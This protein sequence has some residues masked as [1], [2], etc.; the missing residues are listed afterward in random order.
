[1]EQWPTFFIV[2]AQ[3]A[4]TTSLYEYLKEIPSIYMSA[5][6]EPNY[7]AVSVN[8]D[9]LLITPIRDKAKYLELFQNAKQN[10][11][12]GDASPTYLWDPKTPKLIHEVVPSAKIIIILRNPVERAYSHYFWLVVTKGERA[13]FEDLIKKSNKLSHKDF[14][15]RVISAGFYSEQVKRYLETFGPN[16]IKIIIFEEFIKEPKLKVKEILKF[17]D[18]KEE[19]PAS[20]GTVFNQAII[21]RSGLSSRILKN[22]MIKKTARRLFPP[23]IGEVV[24]KKILGK[25]ET[26]PEMSEKDRKFLEQI[27]R[28]DIIKLEKYINRKLPWKFSNSSATYEK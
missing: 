28:E 25:K 14:S 19:P 8:D 26:K 23:S 12:I 9:E 20:V 1:M 17:L 11:L 6:K 27:Y 16:Q 3:R 24:I 10:A 18:V 21:P 2:G 5:I 4:G 15:G 7:F 13:S 22:K